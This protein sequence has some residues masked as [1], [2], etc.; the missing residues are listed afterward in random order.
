MAAEGYSNDIQILHTIPQLSNI[1]H[2]HH[3][4]RGSARAGVAE[5]CCWLEQT[6]LWHTGYFLI[7]YSTVS[8]TLPRVASSYIDFRCIYSHTN[9]NGYKQIISLQYPK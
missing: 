9:V 5:E 1:Q 6:D 3:G 2:G 7:K 8:F 4:L